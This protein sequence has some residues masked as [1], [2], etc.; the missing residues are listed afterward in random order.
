MSYGVFFELYSHKLLS[1]IP[2]ADLSLIGGT[3]SFLALALSLVVGCLLDARKHRWIVGVGMILYVS[4][5][6]G[7]SFAEHSYAFVWLSSAFI[8]G[9]GM[10]CFFMYSS[11]NAIEVCLGSTTKSSTNLQNIVVST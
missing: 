3:Q 5:L 11:Q 10:S 2:D 7:L 6:I 8:V 4:G 1:Q 9:I